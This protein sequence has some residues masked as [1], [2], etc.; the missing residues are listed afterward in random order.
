VAG[1]QPGEPEPGGAA[2]DA[3]RLVHARKAG[4]GSVCHN[5]G[6]AHC[7]G[8]CCVSG[9]CAGQLTEG[10]HAACAC[11]NAAGARSRCAREREVCLAACW[12]R[13]TSCHR[14]HVPHRCVIHP[15]AHHMPAQVAPGYVTVI[16]ARTQLSRIFTSHP[17]PSQAPHF[18]SSISRSFATHWEWDCAAGVGPPRHH[19][20]LF[21]RLW[22]AVGPTWRLR[23]S[24]MCTPARWPTRTCCWCRRW[25]QLR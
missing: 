7:C 25:A 22:R 13:K 15:W 2:H 19:C 24:S 14:A 12:P 1:E 9:S 16:N 4:G 8:G 20:G 21:R 11:C 17:G 3:S 10:L 18:T 6:A 23:A 5:K